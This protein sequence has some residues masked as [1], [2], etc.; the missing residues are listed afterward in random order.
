MT[1]WSIVVTLPASL[2]GLTC[3]NGDCTLTG[4]TLTIQNM[5]YNG[6]LAPNAT[7][8]FGMSFTSSSDTMSFANYA[9][10]GDS[11]QAS[12]SDFVPISGLTATMDYQNGWQS[13]GAYV[14]QYNVTV[15]NSSGAKVKAWRIEVSNW[16][17]ATHSVVNLWNANY[18]S[19]PTRLLLLSQ[20]ALNNASTASF[21]GQLQVP[22]STW[23]PTY[24]VKGK[25]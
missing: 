18:T 7:T 25:L 5:S 3:W 16:N 19:E 13:N 10:T 23:S 4:T 17:D 9:A 12:D 8:D 20:G 14:K 1:G 15:T 22:I 2:T 6:S 11:A 21:G 24:V